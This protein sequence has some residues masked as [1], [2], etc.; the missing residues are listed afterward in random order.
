M[1]RRSVARVSSDLLLREDP[2]FF[3]PVASK[4][5]VVDDVR[6]CRGFRRL[7]EARLEQ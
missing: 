6:R 3:A 1:R 4:Q 5:E 7:P 2:H